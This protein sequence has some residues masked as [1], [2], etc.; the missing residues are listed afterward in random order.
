MIRRW[1]SYYEP[2]NRIDYAIT[3]KKSILGLLLVSVLATG[4]VMGERTDWRRSDRENASLAFA[5][6]K[7]PMRSQG[8]AVKHSKGKA[9]SKKHQKQR[10]YTPLTGIEAFVSKQLAAARAPLTL[11]TFDPN[12]EKP[13]QELLESTI[14][15]HQL[16]PHYLALIEANHEKQAWRDSSA[17]LYRSKKWK[18][19]M[20]GDR[21]IR[22]VFELE[23]SDM[24]AI[25]EP[26]PN[27]KPFFTVP[28]NVLK[29]F[30]NE[31]RAYTETLRDVVNENVSFLF[32]VPFFGPLT[33]RA[34]GS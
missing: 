29:T 34:M 13:L 27:A 33:F 12:K 31:E 11:P 22:S 8:R 16:P 7:K 15:Y 17:S 2:R 14:N 5:A 28:D 3:Y 25:F 4:T 24:M 10:T 26:V 6:K 9:N 30:S 32:D 21:I 1:R 19:E 23:S 20:L 18:F